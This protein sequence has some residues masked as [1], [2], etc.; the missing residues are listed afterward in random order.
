MADDFD[1]IGSLM[2]ILNAHDCMWQER[3][4]IF[5]AASLFAILYTNRGRISSTFKGLDM[6][7]LLVNPPPLASTGTPS[8]V[9]RA[10]QRLPQ[11]TAG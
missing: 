3:Q 8:G 4:R 6:L 5:T 11:E 9:S 7:Q 2:R 1:V 10:L